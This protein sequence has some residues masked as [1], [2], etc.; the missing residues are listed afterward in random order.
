MFE[1]QPEPIE[2]YFTTEAQN[3]IHEQNAPAPPTY[4]FWQV[5]YWR[6][7]FDVDTVQVGKRLLFS[8]FPYPKFFQAIQ[9]N[10]DL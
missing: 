3:L 4:N 8:L 7:I 10:P 5:E 2:N 6:F 1:K 9:P